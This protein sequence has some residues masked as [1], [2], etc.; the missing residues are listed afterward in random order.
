MRPHVL[1]DLKTWSI[2][3]LYK[4]LDKLKDQLNDI[5]D[6]IDQGQ[7]DKK[8]LLKRENTI[9]YLHTIKEIIK[10]KLNKLI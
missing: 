2:K 4:K 6:R 9:I 5:E 7:M 3:S 8:T 10:N 1:K